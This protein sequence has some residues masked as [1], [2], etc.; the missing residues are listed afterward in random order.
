MRGLGGVSGLGGYLRPEILKSRLLKRYLEGLFAFWCR[1]EPAFT[2]SF[3]R[4]G[5]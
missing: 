4:M 5:H 1:T 2:V 3:N